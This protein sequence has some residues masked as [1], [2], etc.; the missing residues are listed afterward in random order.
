VENLII[1]GQPIQF[2]WYGVRRMLRVIIH[3]DIPEN[4]CSVVNGFG[5]GLTAATDPAWEE[6]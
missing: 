1:T 5:G 2:R 3:I 4:K 6:A